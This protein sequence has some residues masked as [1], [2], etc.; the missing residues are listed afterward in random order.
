MIELFTYAFT[1]P[2]GIPSPALVPAMS[3]PH[4]LIISPRACP[5]PSCRP[6]LGFMAISVVVFLCFF[7]F[8]WSYD[9]LILFDLSVVWLLIL[10]C[11]FYWCGNCWILD[12][13]GSWWKDVAKT[14]GKKS[15]FAK[16][17]GSS[18]TVG[19]WQ[20]RSWAMTGM[21]TAMPHMLLE[22]EGVQDQWFARV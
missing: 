19:S 3:C 5:R 18:R 9:D 7:D 8:V 17:W 13:F 2:L 15:P 14:W 1:P 22:E 6:L 21:T 12:V 4:P 10:F 16:T 11:S 20:K